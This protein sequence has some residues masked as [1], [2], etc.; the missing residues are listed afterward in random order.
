MKTP[1]DPKIDKEVVYLETSFISYLVSE[2]SSN[3][4]SYGNQL[5]TKS[6]WEKNKKKYTFIVSE[7]VL[8][9]SEKGKRSEAKK[10]LDF[11]SDIK[12]VLVE[13][14]DIEIAKLIIK[15]GIIPEKALSDAIHIST[16]ARY[17]ASYLLTWNCK[18]IANAQNFRA[19]EE[20]YA[21]QALY[22]PILC[23]PLQLGEF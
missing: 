16:A 4:I 2:P 17:G 23:T 7:L 15:Q 3:I 6:W 12:S 5:Q 11:L 14:K 13:Q 8:L 20:L 21:K 1:R 18:H 22:L 10:R 19:L 9:E